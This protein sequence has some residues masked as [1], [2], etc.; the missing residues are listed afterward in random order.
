MQ[1]A[2]E[3]FFKAKKDIY[4]QNFGNMQ[5]PIK[6][7]GLDFKE[8]KDYIDEDLKKINWKATAKSGA[9]KAN[10]FNETRQ[11]NIV[12]VLMLSGSLKFGS[13]RL[14]RD[15]ATEIFALLSLAAVESKNLLYPI[16]FSDK[17]EKFYPALKSQ[18]GVYQAIEDSLNIDV[19]GKDVDY[20]NLCDTINSTIRR[21]SAIFIISDFLKEPDFTDIAYYNDVYSIIIRDKIEEELKFDSD[22]DLINPVKLDKFELHLDKSV[23]ER[24]KELLKEHD[25]KVKNHF[26]E[27]RI[28]S[29]KIYTDD[30]VLPKL[31]KITRS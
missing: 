11:I 24:Y 3:I 10:V 29:D 14:K 4:N 17:L 18:D 6:G 25:R 22:M 1:R 5:S 13:V 31:I 27:N 2:K 21:K 15:L 23:V 16:I 28:F 19:L 7:D 12:V 20:K 26:L 9:I 8:I 30:E